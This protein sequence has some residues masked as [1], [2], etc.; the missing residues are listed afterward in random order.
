MAHTALSQNV[1]PRQL[2]GA[3]PGRSSNDLVARI[4]H[5]VEHAMHRRQKATL[6]TLEVQGAFDAVLHGRLLLRLRKIGWPE[7]AVDWVKSFLDKRSARVRHEDGVTEPVFLECELPQGSPLSPI[8]FLLHMA[9][10]VGESRWRFS[11]ADNVVILGVGKYGYLE[12]I[13]SP[14]K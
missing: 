10:V 11:Y 8:F 1:V 9:E 12:T 5:D 13:I 4:I 7:L 3:L 6:V 2:F 14:T